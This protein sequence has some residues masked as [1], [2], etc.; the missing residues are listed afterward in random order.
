MFC[1]RMDSQF[2]CLEFEPRLYLV[3]IHCVSLLELPARINLYNVVPG[4]LAVHYSNAHTISMVRNYSSLKENQDFSN[5]D[6]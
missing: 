6:Y 4:V 2:K 5:V 3:S 1:F